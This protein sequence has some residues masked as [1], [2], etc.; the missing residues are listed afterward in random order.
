MGVPRWVPSE[1]TIRKSRTGLKYDVGW[2]RVWIV[3]ES[4]TKPQ[5]I[6]AAIPLPTGMLPS[7]DTPFDELLTLAT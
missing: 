6:S 1:Y 3:N 5:R 4:T 7:R 2:T